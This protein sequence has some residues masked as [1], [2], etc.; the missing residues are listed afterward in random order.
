MGRLIH[1]GFVLLVLVTFAPSLGAVGYVV[2]PGDLEATLASAAP[3]D[4]LRLEAGVHR[5]PIT[6]STQ[7]HLIGDPGAIIQG[8]NHGTTLILAADGITVRGL[9]VRGSG[10]DLS[11]D[12]AVVLIDRSSNVTVENCRVEARGFGIYLKAGGEHRIINNEIS[13]DPALPIARRGNGIHLWHTENNIVQDNHLVDVRDGIYLSF[14]HDNL[15]HR[16]EGATLRYGIHYMYSERNT[17]TENRFTACTGGIALMFSMKNRI[18]SNELT[19]NE[20]FGLLCQQLEHSLL[21]DNYLAGNGRGFYIQNSAANEFI[22]NR[23]EGNGVGAYL[24]AGSERNLFTM[25]RFDG[26]LVQVFEDHPGDHSG[27]NA[28][29]RAGRGNFWSDYA[30]FDWNGD[31]VGETPYRLVTA[32]SALLARRP[33]AR[34]FWMSPI[35]TLLNWWDARLKLPAVGSFDPFPLIA[36]ASFSALEEEQ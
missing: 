35:L 20:Q 2:P 5:G 32:A 9:T 27:A 23:L 18:A 36:D 13:G 21:E 33:E 24:T 30:G 15:I 29:F 19:D 25:N 4:T 26:N 12:D 34:W 3:G 28:F 16:N 6:I 22:G 11:R 14:A 1:R 7:V 17:L 10:A 31:G 8:A